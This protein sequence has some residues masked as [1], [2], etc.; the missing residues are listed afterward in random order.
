MRTRVKESPT[1]TPATAPEQLRPLV[2]HSQNTSKKDLQVRLPPLQTLEDNDTEDATSR[3]GYLAGSLAARRRKAEPEGNDWFSSSRRVLFFLAVAFLFAFTVGSFQAAGETEMLRIK[4]AASAL[5]DSGKRQT[6]RSPSL[7]LSPPPP[8]SSTVEAHV[9]QIPAPPRISSVPPSPLQEVNVADYGARKNDVTGRIPRNVYAMKGVVRSVA[10]KLLQE[11]FGKPK[12]PIKLHVYDIDVEAHNPA[13]VWD[14][15]CGSRLKLCNSTFGDPEKMETGKGAFG[16]C[17]EFGSEVLL[18]ESIS[19]SPYHTNSI[20]DADYVFVKSCIMGRGI[21]GQYQTK[22]LERVQADPVVGKRFKDARSSIVL[23]LT[24]DH[25]ACHNRKE[26]NGGKSQKRNLSLPMTER[27]IAPGFEGATVM[28]HEGSLVGLGCYE[29][30]WASTIPT[31]AAS[32]PL[33]A[34]SCENIT[35]AEGGAHHKH[36]ATIDV[37]SNNKHAGR[38]NL[39]F[40][41]GKNSAGIRR[42]IAEV[43]VKQ[44]LSVYDDAV[45]F[46]YP[47]YVCAMRSSVFCFAPRGN[48]VWS[49][50]LEESLAAGCI[51]IIVADGYDLPFSRI[52][53]YS[54]FSVRLRQGKIERTH[55]VLASISEGE[56]EQMRKYG[57][58]ALSAFRYAAG[59]KV[60]EPGQDATP[61]VAFQLWLRAKNKLHELDASW[62]LKDQYF[63][64]SKLKGQGRCRSNC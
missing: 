25:G 4:T 52:L 48:A 45:R 43:I 23:T 27:W 56:R 42:Q 16:Y 51:P 38:P 1:P 37:H 31:G 14:T 54:T 12:V 46:V 10:W 22:L 11:F 41:S 30:A 36:S 18:A 20:D 47:S 64:M 58:L 13:G 61:F 8:S 26:R 63:N 59:T 5:D 7:S 24:A 19:T 17:R 21:N 6:P 50:R 49:P 35:V 32:F 2:Q 55:E 53:D 40:F 44:K 57:K 29:R 15:L 9:E 34:L 28:Q 60:L 39:V 3:G 33:E 62:V